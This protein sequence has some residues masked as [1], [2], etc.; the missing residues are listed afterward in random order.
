MAKIAVPVV[1]LQRIAP[2]PDEPTLAVAQ[3]AGHRCVVP[4][5]QFNEQSL[6]AFISAGAVLP[7]WVLQRLG[8]WDERAGRG[9][10]GGPAGDRVELRIIHG[11]VSHGLCYPVDPATFHDVDDNPEDGHVLHVSQH[12]VGVPGFVVREG[13]DVAAMLGI[14]EEQPTAADAAS[15]PDALIAAYQLPDGWRIE[16]VQR[17]ECPDGWAVRKDGDCLGADGLLEPEP[18]PSDRTEDFFDRCRF[19]TPEAA[20][21]AWS[22]RRQAQAVSLVSAFISG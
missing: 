11:V 21:A 17:R 3:V 12:C 19:T 18:Q 5:R 22:A 10:L 8:Y 15:M 2:H 16:R 14:T 9:T 1:Q 13:D 20:Y 4:R 7:A 6:V